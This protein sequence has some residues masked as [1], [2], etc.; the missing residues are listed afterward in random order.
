MLD[1][2]CGP[3]DLTF[4]ILMPNLPSNFQRLVGVDVSNEMIDYAR[5][6]QIH[7]RL[8]FEQFDLCTKLEKQPLNSAEPFDHIFSFYTLMWISTCMKT[9]LE[10]FYKLLIP[11]GDLF[12]LFNGNHPNY[13]VYKEQSLDKRW[14]RYMFDVD[15]ITPST[16]NSKDPVKEFTDLLNKYGFIDCDVRIVSKNQTID[17]SRLRGKS[18]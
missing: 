12:V 14:A 10:S 3:G 2:G 5:K 1:A 8:S 18:F 16:Q 17:Q 15:K 7:P 9:C 6:T 11:N 13:D 4:D